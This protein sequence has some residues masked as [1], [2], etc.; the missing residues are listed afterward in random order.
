MVAQQLERPKNGADDPDLS[1]ELNSMH[2]RIRH[3]SARMVE[4]QAEEEINLRHTLQ[5]QVLKTLD[6]TEPKI[7]ETIRLRATNGAGGIAMLLLML[8]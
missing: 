7:E 6:L 5:P 2:H 8:T 1:G 4:W 3:L